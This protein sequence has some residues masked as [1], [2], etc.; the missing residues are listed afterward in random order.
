MRCFFMRMVRCK[1]V[2][3]MFLNFYCVFKTTGGI[4]NV[5][6]IHARCLIHEILPEKYF[7]REL[8]TRIKGLRHVFFFLTLTLD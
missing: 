5:G 3:A 2:S 7:S 4:C 1:L 6:L 8:I